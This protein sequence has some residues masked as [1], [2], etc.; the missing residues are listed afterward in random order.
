MP[1]RPNA[2]A[3]IF[4]F[5]PRNITENETNPKQHKAKKLRVST[6]SFL[7]VVNCTLIEFKNELWIYNL[8]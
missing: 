7:G 4:A 8:Q 6:Y 1:H 3:L 2:N 5:N